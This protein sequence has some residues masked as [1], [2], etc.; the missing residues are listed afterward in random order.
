MSG[1]RRILKASVI[2]LATLFI[3]LSETA[4]AQPVLKVEPDKGG[5]GVSALVTNTGNESATNIS[6]SMKISGTF[7]FYGKP[8]SGMIPTLAPNAS[9]IIKTGPIIG[10]GTIELDANATCKEGATYDELMVGFV[11]LFYVVRLREPLP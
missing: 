7:L 4:F 10:F 6:W 9:A 5:F 1:R 2:I 3:I 11:L 8:V